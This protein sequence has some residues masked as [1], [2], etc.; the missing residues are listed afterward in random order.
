VWEDEGKGGGQIDRLF[1]G[2]SRHSAHTSIHPIDPPTHPPSTHT[3]IHPSNRPTHP[4]D[5]PTH[6]PPP[7]THINPHTTQHD[8]VRD[9]ALDLGEG[10]LLL[11]PS[12][13]PLRW[14]AALE[15]ATPEVRRRK[16]RVVV[17]EPRK[18]WWEEGGW[19]GRSEQA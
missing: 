12:D 19:V 11:C 5:P 8:S 2:L 9:T 17:V 18:G 14:V 16:K 6:E 3:H 15:E 1:R 10:R 4:I 7:P 13:P